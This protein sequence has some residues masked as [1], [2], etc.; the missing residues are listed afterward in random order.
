VVEK[1]WNEANYLVSDNRFDWTY[2]AVDRLIS[3]LE[4]NDS[5]TGYK[6][7]WVYDL[8][9]NRLTRTKLSG[10]AAKKVIYRLVNA[11]DGASLPSGFSLRSFFVHW[12]AFQ[13]MHEGRWRNASVFS[14]RE[15]V[16]EIFEPKPSLAGLNAHPNA[17]PASMLFQCYYLLTGRVPILGLTHDSLMQLLY[18][19]RFSE[20]SS[21]VKF[22]EFVRLLAQCISPDPND[23]PRSMSEI[24]AK[25]ANIATAFPWSEMQSEK[26]WQENEQELIASSKLKEVHLTFC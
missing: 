18:M 21:N 17:I 12:L 13:S 6:L 23:G 16:I 1:I 5:F 11:D 10:G 15:R 3:E 4:T 9:G 20:I 2:D 26:W 24:G 19:G 8:S 25:L 14:R 7:D 22:N